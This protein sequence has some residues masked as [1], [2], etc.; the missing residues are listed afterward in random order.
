MKKC[1]QCGML[2][3][4]TATV[5]RSCHAKFSAEDKPIDAPT[6]KK[7]KGIVS[8]IIVAVLFLGILALV[9]QKTGIITNMIEKSKKEEIEAIAAE[10]IYADFECDGQKASEHMFESYIKYQKEN[11]TLN[12]DSYSSIYFSAFSNE[13][14]IEISSIETSFIKDE[15]KYYQAE[16][17]SKY[18]VEAKEIA[19]LTINIQTTDGDITAQTTAIPTVIKIDKDWYIMPLF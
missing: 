12:I 6:N 16:I 11:G 15:F 5:C 17:K 9:I 18:G 13:I 1:R 7:K 3:A 2:S 8:T 19:I 4:D 10:F 14:S